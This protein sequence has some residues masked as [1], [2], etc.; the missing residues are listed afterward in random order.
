M[1]A[2]STDD[3]SD[4]V[5]TSLLVMGTAALP[6]QLFKPYYFNSD[7]NIDNQ[8]I[9]GIEVFSNTE[10]PILPDG[11]N[12]V[13]S[14]DVFRNFLLTLVG[15]DGKQIYSIVP[16]SMLLGVRYSATSYA[17]TPLFDY[18]D[19]VWDKC[20]VQCVDTTA[21]GININDTNILFKIYTKPKD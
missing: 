3:F 10:M 7:S 19:I 18:D 6:M 13:S 5:D 2:D 17:K 21:G 11:K 1:I 20:Y 12:N 4:S 15:G 9:V 14:N 8:K 16:L